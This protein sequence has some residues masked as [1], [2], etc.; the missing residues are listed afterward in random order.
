MFVEALRTVAWTPHG[1]LGQIYSPL[2]VVRE[3]LLSCPYVSMLGSRNW[4]PHLLL[5]RRKVGSRSYKC[6]HW[7]MGP[8]STYR[9]APLYHQ[10][11]GMSLSSPVYM[12]SF[13]LTEVRSTGPLVYVQAVAASRV[14]WPACLSLLLLLYLWLQYKPNSVQSLIVF[15]VA[16]ICIRKVSF[17]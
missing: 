6:F 4:K 14:P 16:C 11:C 17:Q 15:V 10:T 1:D 3:T 13:Q 8:W 5:C 9:Q 7:V 12:P 2:A